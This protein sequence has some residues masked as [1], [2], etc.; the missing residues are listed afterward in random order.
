MEIIRG[1]DSFHLYH[2]EPI[3]LALGNFDGVHC[4][5]QV[6]IRTTVD[7]AR[8]HNKKSA[9]LIFSPHPTM[10]LR[11][12]RTTKLLLTVEDR[13]RMLGEAGVDYVIIHPFTPEFAAITPQQFITEILHRKLSAAGVVVG[14]D[15]SFGSRG[16]GKPADLQKAAAEL[17]FLVQIVERV[18]IGGE[19]VSSTAIRQLLQQG[20]LDKANLMLG[21]PYFLRGMVI[22]GDGRGRTLGFPTAN[23]QPPP[24]I[25]LPANG[26]YLTQVK[27]KEEEYWALTNVGLRPTFNKDEISVEVYLLTAQKNLY[28]QELIVSFLQRIREERKFP[29]AS[30][31]VAQI[32]ADVRQAKNMIKKMSAEKEIAL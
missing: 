10:I 16:R 23:L 13:I 14:Y 5:H 12:E 21:Y 7:L 26:V 11:P 2:Q 4:G 6:I 15:Y 27:V 3:Y 8:A 25:I 30:A 32:Q 29:D 28:Q 22:H 20:D 1:I 9:V 19:P 17:G 24:E 18:S 31:L